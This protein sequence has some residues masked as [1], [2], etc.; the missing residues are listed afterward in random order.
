MNCDS[1]HVPPEVS[2]QFVFWQVPEV[3]VKHKVES[4]V[5][6]LAHGEMARVKVPGTACE[7]SLWLLD[8]DDVP[9]NVNRGETVMSVVWTIGAPR[10][11]CEFAALHRWKS[12]QVSLDVIVVEK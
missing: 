6:L 8:T 7:N 2:G 1:I 5:R 11:E 10:R 12:E 4:F 3:E 9:Q